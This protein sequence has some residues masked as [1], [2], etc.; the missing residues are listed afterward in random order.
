M[1]LISRICV[2]V[3]S[4]NVSI[5]G[6]HLNCPYRKLTRGIPIDL[7][8]DHILHRDWWFRVGDYGMTV[9]QWW[10]HL[11]CEWSLVFVVFLCVS[12]HWIVL[13][14]HTPFGSFWLKVCAVRASGWGEWKHYHVFSMEQKQFESQ[15]RSPPSLNSTPSPSLNESGF[16][17][18]LCIC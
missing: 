12:D 9:V 1:F 11:L 14:W 16:L 7:Q 17:S 15:K 2:L 18:H 13:A 5:S 4:I 8:G 6:T 3:G 10:Q